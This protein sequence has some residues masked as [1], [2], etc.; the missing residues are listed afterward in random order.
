MIQ[1]KTDTHMHT[2]ASGH[3][4]STVEE[5]AYTA[6]KRGLELIGIADHFSELFVSSV[7]SASFGYYSNKKALPPVWHGVRLLFGAEADIVDL[8]GHLFGWDRMV[9]FGPFE[10]PTFK[11]QYLD[12]LDYVVASV[13]FAAFT[14]EASLIQTTEM[15]C[16]A[17]DDP[18]VKVIGHIG[19]ARVPFDMDTVLLHAKELGKMI[20]IN[21]GSFIYADAVPVCTRIA[22]RCAELGTK[23]TVSSDAHSAF[24]VGRFPEA[25][26]MLEEI[27]FPEELIVSRDKKSFLEA[28]GLPDA[29]QEAYDEDRKIYE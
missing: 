28:V 29:P 20:E 6:S 19:R 26:K 17:L 12:K 5:N 7:D 23:I 14:K 24:Y 8:D 10:G 25:G 4:Y 1:I 11:E 13:H 2:L 9:K 15:Y 27:H 18:K 3:A 21:E 16:K 22:E